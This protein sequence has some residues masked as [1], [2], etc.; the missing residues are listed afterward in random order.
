MKLMRKVIIKFCNFLKWFS[1]EFELDQKDKTKFEKLK[2]Y[3]ES[4]DK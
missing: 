2:T 1:E 3:F 4:E